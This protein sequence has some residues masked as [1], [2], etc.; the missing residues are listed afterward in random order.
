MI[1]VTPN[2]FPW[3][4]MKKN[5]FKKVDS[6]RGKQSAYTKRLQYD[7][8]TVIRWCNHFIAF[9]MTV[10]YILYKCNITVITVIFSRFY[11]TFVSYIYLPECDIFI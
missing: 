9:Y 10:S 4:M 11:V 1:Q 7:C 2:S 6:G 5:F 3:N 8:W